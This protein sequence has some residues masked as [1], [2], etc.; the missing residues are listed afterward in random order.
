[1]YLAH[2]GMNFPIPLWVAIFSG[3]EQAQEWKIVWLNFPF[4]IA[5]SWKLARVGRNPSTSGSCALMHSISG[6]SP[7]VPDGLHSPHNYHLAQGSMV[8][9]EKFKIS[10]HVFR[11]NSRRGKTL[12][13]STVSGTFSS[14]LN[15]LLCIF[16]L[17]RTPKIMQLVL[18][19]YLVLGSDLNKVHISS[20]FQVALET[21]VWTTS[22]DQQTFSIKDNRVNILSFAGQ[23]ISDMTTQIQLCSQKYINK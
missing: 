20:A 11:K 8:L 9:N 18:V 17:H 13:L 12:Y 4:T 22:G 7:W 16:I 21:I 5:G 10:K 1:M 2:P 3:L 6:W 19:L 15:K 23:T 14:F